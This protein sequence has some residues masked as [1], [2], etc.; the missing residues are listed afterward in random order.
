MSH[1]KKTRSFLEKHKD[2]LN[3]IADETTI[4][5]ET[6]TGPQEAP[7]LLEFNVNPGKFRQYR[8]QKQHK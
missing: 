6:Q 5:D 4:Y 2:I 8:K 1:H 3:E 7:Y